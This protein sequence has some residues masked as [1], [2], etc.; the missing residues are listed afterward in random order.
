MINI[1]KEEKDELLEKTKTKIIW[2]L[3]TK[4]DLD[5]IIYGD[6]KIHGGVGDSNSILN[7]LSN[8]IM[9]LLQSGIPKYA[10]KKAIKTG[11]NWERYVI[12]DE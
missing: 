4:D 2:E 10:I 12:E 6:G 7:A 1:D 9:G 5:C 11:L 3:Q 8:L